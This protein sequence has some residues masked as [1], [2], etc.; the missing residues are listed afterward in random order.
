MIILTAGESATAVVLGPGGPVGTAWLLGLAAGLRRAGVDLADAD[1][2]IGTS[3]GAIAG[4][5]LSAGRDLGEVADLPPAPPGRRAGDPTV[6]PR[7]LHI[8]N[9]PGI[10]PNE[11][12]RQVGALALQADALPEE[13]HL[14]AMEHLIGTRTW[15]DIP[16]L[17]TA[18]DAESGE[19]VAWSRDSGVPL[20]AAVAASSAAPGYAVP[21]TI[22]GHRYMDG[23]LGGGSNARLADGAGTL[24]LIEP[25]GHLLAATPVEA[26][27]RIG[28]DRA[29]LE[30]FGPDVGDR[31][32]W[33][34]VYKSG[35]R[36]SAGIADRIRPHLPGR[37]ERA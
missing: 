4:A 22:D 1:L 30:A 14:T 36:Q 37:S 27:V 12:L 9:A 26:D 13:Q 5:V 28:P 33:A 18:V 16:L 8:L 6:M 11:A 34:Q 29:A 2:L 31:S 15:P 17:I 19:R 3:A 25:I 24:I 23:A 20:H 21:I 35:H 10:D 7:V 32:R